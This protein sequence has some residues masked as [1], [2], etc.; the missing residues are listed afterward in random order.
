[1][2]EWKEIEGT[3][4]LLEVSSLGNV[5][6]NMRDGRIL[7]AQTTRK[8]YL[9]IRVTV[10]RERVS[11]PVHRAVAKA[12]IPNPNN[13]PQVNHIDGDK[14][15]NR[16]ENLEWVT[17][18]ENAHHAMANGLWANVYDA[19]LRTNADKRTPVRSIDAKTGEVR[20]FVSVSDAE[21]FFN[22]RH[23]SDVL[24]GKREK[25]AGQYFSRIEG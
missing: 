7:K 10:K 11:I 6:S 15:N 2:E 3:Y 12:F 21:R 19:S 18:Y 22:S 9:R 17:N 5:R 8:G 25:A 13:L 16:V 1:M 23:I 14:T 4:G 24:N 20:E